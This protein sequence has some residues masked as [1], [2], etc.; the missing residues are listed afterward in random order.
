MYNIADIQLFSKL[1][2]EH[3][4]AIKQNAIVRSYSKDSIV[5][6]EEEKGGLFDLLSDFSPFCYLLGSM[7]IVLKW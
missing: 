4:K 5:F 3:Q 7:R 6:Y 1:S 2:E